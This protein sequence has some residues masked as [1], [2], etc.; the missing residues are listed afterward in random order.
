MTQ[1]PVSTKLPFCLCPLYFGRCLLTALTP[2][3][4]LRIYRH[5][6]PRYVYVHADELR[7]TMNRVDA[8][9]R[10]HEYKPRS[11]MTKM[12]ILSI[13][14][15]TSYKR[16]VRVM[17]LYIYPQSNRAHPT[18]FI[19]TRS[20]VSYSFLNMFLANAFY[21][22]IFVKNYSAFSWS[23]IFYAEYVPVFSK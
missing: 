8:C 3:T 22:F 5:L 14:L 7:R 23:S 10:V 4:T 2:Q 11:R 1:W 19:P 6:R 20:T 13:A 16:D 17:W 15:A 9:S 18:E 21:S 12:A